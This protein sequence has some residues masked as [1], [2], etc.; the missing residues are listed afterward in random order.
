M[1]KT[2]KF[3]IRAL[4]IIGGAILYTPLYKLTERMEN[5]AFQ[6]HLMMDNPTWYNQPWDATV[7]RTVFFIFLIVGIVFLFTA[8]KKQ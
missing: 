3:L 4:A 6:D 8:D 7:F 2:K 5:M 1:T